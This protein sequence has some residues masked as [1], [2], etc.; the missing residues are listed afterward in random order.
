MSIWNA[1][2]LLASSQLSRRDG[3]LWEW[4]GTDV[5]QFGDGD[6]TPTA[7]NGGTATG[8]LAAAT[9]AT[10]TQDV[11]TD[12]ALVFTHTGASNVDSY[13]IINDLPPLPERFRIVAHLGPRETSNLGANT[14]PAIVLAWQDGT[15][16][17]R[18]YANS[19]KNA[20]LVVTGN[21]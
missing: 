6:G 14:Y 11:Q 10:A 16:F 1:S 20:L 15:H 13:Y 17:M 19:A 8:T 2:N 5:S 4:N 21:G 12:K 3:L 9:L 7:V 18:L